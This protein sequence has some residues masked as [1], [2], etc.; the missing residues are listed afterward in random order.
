MVQN[1]ALMVGLSYVYEKT[2][3][4]LKFRKFFDFI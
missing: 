2:L 4:F 3:K 1:L